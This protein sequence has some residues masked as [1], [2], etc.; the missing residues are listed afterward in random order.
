VSSRQLVRHWGRKYIEVINGL[1]NEDDHVIVGPLY[2]GYYKRL[3][4]ITDPVY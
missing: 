2:I 4:A 1:I 3:H